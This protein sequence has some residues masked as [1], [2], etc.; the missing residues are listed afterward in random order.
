MCPLPTP[1]AASSA[2]DFSSIPL[3]NLRTMRQTTSVHQAGNQ[4]QLAAVKQEM[5]ERIII[6]PSIGLFSF[7]SDIQHSLILQRTSQIALITTL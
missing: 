3:S 1:T 5:L 2:A 4:N 7:K 6:S